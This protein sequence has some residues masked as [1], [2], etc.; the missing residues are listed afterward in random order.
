MPRPACTASVS[1]RILRLFFTGV[2]GEFRR[3]MAQCKNVERRL[4]PV[5]ARSGSTCLASFSPENS[6]AF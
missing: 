3:E 2:S 4:P 1:I 6:P 5:Q